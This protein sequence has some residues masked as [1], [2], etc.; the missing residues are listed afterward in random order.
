MSENQNNLNEN[1][2]E[3]QSDETAVS[4]KSS[5]MNE[6]FDWVESIII[7]VIAIILIFTFLVRVTS[8]DGSSM[9]PTL[10]DQERL[11][12]TDLFYS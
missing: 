5:F 4:T 8:V 3:I 9:Y 12:V 2:N 1:N 10:V 6:A 7:A 11:L